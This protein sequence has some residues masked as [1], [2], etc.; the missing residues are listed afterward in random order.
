MDPKHHRTKRIQK[1]L[2]PVAFLIIVLLSVI[3]YK[4]Q[5]T[6]AWD[7]A[8]ITLV[9]NS[10]QW[11]QLYIDGVASCSANPGDQCT[12]LVDV[13]SHCLE[14][15]ATDGRSVRQCG[16]ISEHGV[17]FVISDE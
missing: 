1:L 14:A 5:A 7:T 4:A 15:V 11:L 16:N 12:D 10:S 13:G 8:E 6:E 17:R 2:V 3:G 9:N